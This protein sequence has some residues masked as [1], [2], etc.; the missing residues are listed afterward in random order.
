MVDGSREQVVSSVRVRSACAS[1]GTAALPLPEEVRPQFAAE[2]A[3]GGCVPARRAGNRDA[4]VALGHCI[5]SN[6]DGGGICPSCPIIVGD[7]G[8]RE[9]V[10]T[11]TAGG[12]MAARVTDG[13]CVT[14]EAAILPPRERQ[15]SGDEDW[16]W[17]AIVA[18]DFAGTP[19]APL[20]FSAHGASRRRAGAELTPKKAMDDGSEAATTTPGG[21]SSASASSQVDGGEQLAQELERAQLVLQNGA[22]AAAERMLNAR[23]SSSAV[24]AKARGDGVEE[25][26]RIMAAAAILR[27]A[28]SAAGVAVAP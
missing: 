24:A 11:T 14:S 9:H 23:R 1:V 15:K 20:I 2:G 27:Q 18:A 6:L 17:E 4:C 5:A 3:P 8:Q 25:D 16:L 7:D 13:Q 21:Q 26:A 10:R 19:E 22:V 28:F 12:R